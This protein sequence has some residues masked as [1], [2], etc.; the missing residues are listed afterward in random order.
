MG[1]LAKVLSRQYNVNIH[2]GSSKLGMT[3][4]SISLRNKETIGDVI[5]ALQRISQMTVQRRGK[6]IYLSD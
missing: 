3:R 1:E 5:D 4:F 6:D 2:V